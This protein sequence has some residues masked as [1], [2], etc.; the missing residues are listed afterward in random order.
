MGV[1]DVPSHLHDV[2]SQVWVGVLTSLQDYSTAAE[3]RAS[4]PQ[5]YLFTGRIQDA[6]SERELQL[7]LS[8]PYQGR[9]ALFLKLP[10]TEDFPL[11][12]S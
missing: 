5:T 11:M 8:P 1:A 4:H 6:V 12:V 7:P 9:K 3:V 10:E 2:R